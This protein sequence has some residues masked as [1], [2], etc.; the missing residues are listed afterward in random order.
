MQRN[1]QLE[2]DLNRERFGLIRWAQQAFRGLRVIPPGNGILHQINLELLARVVRVEDDGGECL[3]LPD[4]LVGMDSHTPM[5]NSQGVLGWG[6]GGIEAS[7]A[8]LGEPISLPK[9]TRPATNSWIA[10]VSPRCGTWVSSSLLMRASSSA[11]SDRPELMPP[12]A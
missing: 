1:L 2:F 5:V 11:P 4:T 8:M 3:A 10:P 7:S 12:D 9:S 6:V